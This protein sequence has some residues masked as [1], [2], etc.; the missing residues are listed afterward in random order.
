MALKKIAFISC[1]LAALLLPGT[2]DDFEKYSES[3]KTYMFIEAVKDMETAKV[4]S[5]IPKLRDINAA[6]SS[7][8]VA[9]VEAAGPVFST[10]K[11]TVERR[12]AMLKMLIAGK[13]DVNRQDGRGVT[14]LIRASEHG[15]IEI[16][17]LLLEHKADVNLADKTGFT[18]LAWACEK[19]N[20]ALIEL[21]AQNKADLNVKNSLGN[22]PL[23]TALVS[24]DAETA[25]ILISRG[26][27][28][29]IK[30]KNGASPL[31]AAIG[32]GDVPVTGLLLEKGASF[33]D[34][35]DALFLAYDRGRFELFG[36]LA[37]KG[38]PV[39]CLTR[40]KEPLLI[41]ILRFAALFPQERQDHLRYARVLLEHGVDVNARGGDGDTALILSLG[42]GDAD[43]AGA[44][45]AGTKDVNARGLHERTA[46]MAAAR[47]G[48]L[49]ILR[50][51]ADKGAR[52]H[53][54]DAF[55]WTALMHAATPAIFDFL[56]PKKAVLGSV[57]APDEFGCSPLAFAVLKDNLPL[58]RALLDAGAVVDVRIEAPGWNGVSP[59]IMAA[60][61]ARFEI[62]R[63]LLDRGANVNFA[64]HDGMTAMDWVADDPR[65]KSLLVSRGGKPGTPVDGGE[66]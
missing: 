63:L 23:L 24:C 16:V 38:A 42:S 50:S 10:D 66:M 64:D 60:S 7:G 19:K 4:A 41:H 45:L 43:I 14:A 3:S 32:C 25:L 13:A 31:S 28:V 49:D 21:L 29:R 12:I 61:L 59:L 1:F 22:T 62:A 8:N 2:A 51:L 46:V 39:N 44:V 65:M 27:D 37:G 30:N 17:R 11:F 52:L 36:V 18:P 48:F 33:A 56:L 34:V 53:D 35:P 40:N 6:D 47:F 26:A 57:N 54:R 5:M 9:I 15:Y 20:R 58:A 55:G